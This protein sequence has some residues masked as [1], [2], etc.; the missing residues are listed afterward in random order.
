[1]AELDPPTPA[2]HGPLVIYIPTYGRPQACLSQVGAVR[3]QAESVSVDVVIV[4]AI[5]GDDQYDPAAFTQRGADVVI[6][7]PLNLGG[8]TNICLGYEYLANSEYVW[9]LSDDDLISPG[10]LSLVVAAMRQRADLIVGTREPTTS[11]W[12][13]CNLLR[14]V[15][16]AGGAVD[17]ISATIYRSEV[18][19]PFV[20]HA[21]NLII[22]S[23]PHAALI[24]RM[25]ETR[26]VTRCLLTPIESLVDRQQSVDQV[27]LV[28]RATAGQRQGAAFFGGGLLATVGAANQFNGAEFGQWW[29]TH[30][31]RASMYRR[32]RSMQQAWVGHMA[33]SSA[34]TYFWWL[35]SLPPWWRAKDKLRPRM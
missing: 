30:W 20:E 3:Q 33:R 23:Y 26:S 17:L 18:A 5:N 9:I 16:V 1:M 35:A 12:L 27:T 2:G 31:H 32:S 7:R 24:K 19:R 8:N 10:A 4:V 22:T 25:L 6:Y 11:G 14:D 34:R 15:K 28:D 13:D 21:F 29:S